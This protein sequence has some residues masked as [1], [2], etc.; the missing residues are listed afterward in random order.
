MYKKY[1][2]K[3]DTSLHLIQSKNSHT[4]QLDNA[5]NIALSNHVSD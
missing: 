2:K 3:H 4:T 5:V 1:Y